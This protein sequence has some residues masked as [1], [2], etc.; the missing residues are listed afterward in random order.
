MGKRTES[1]GEL[2]GTTRTFT[3]SIESG[4]YVK[5]GSVEGWRFTK[6]EKEVGI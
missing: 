1:S 6:R 5:E 4:G 2:W 3:G